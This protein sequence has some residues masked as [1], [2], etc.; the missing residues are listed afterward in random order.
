MADLLRGGAGGLD[1]G[2]GEGDLDG[3]QVRRQRVGDALH[4]VAHLGAAAHRHR[5]IPGYRWGNLG[6]ILQHHWRRAG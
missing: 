6:K 1:G 4:D 3:R 2:L 5:D